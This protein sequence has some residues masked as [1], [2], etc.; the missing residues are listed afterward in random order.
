VAEQYQVLGQ[1]NKNEHMSSKM[2][3]LMEESMT[4]Y[5]KWHGQR[6]I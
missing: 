1:Q 6:G 4:K 3:V 5:G 2:E